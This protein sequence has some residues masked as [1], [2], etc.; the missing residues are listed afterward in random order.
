MQFSPEILR[1]AWF[2]AG[3]TASGKSAA[4]VELAELIGA[5]IVSLDSMSLY[6]GMDI[7]TAKP[8]QAL[9]ERVPHHL[10]DIIDPHEEFSL[11]EYLRV[12]ESACREIQSRGR[13]PLFVGGTGL[14][15][16]AIL[17]GIFE[18]PPADWEF[19][20]RLETE[21]LER[22][23]ESLH[24]RLKAVDPPLAAKLH[25][26]DVRRV[27]RALEV[28]ELTGVPL[29]AQQQQHPLPI[30]HRPR[31]VYWL[32]PDRDWLYQRIDQ[33]VMEMFAAGLVQE[34]QQLREGA[35]AP[36]SRTAQ[37]AL[38]Y[39]EIIEHL[40]G[41]R[42]LEETIALVQ[43]RTRQFAKRQHTWFRNLEE[44]TPIAITGTESPR[45]IASELARH[46]S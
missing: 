32:H 41:M 14:Y 12:A 20:R 15:L 31:H 8:E 44:C 9:R 1:H 28:F 4:G 21:A 24:D 39:K 17:R 16:R 38:G 34:V 30:D 3:P 42:T 6:R 2:L 5:E 43:V 25:P 33:R 35:I 19:R 22:G 27:I 23:E 37:Q 13:V 18:G 10:L 26:S 11:A 46:V 7:G 45:E 36:L 40:A 29:S